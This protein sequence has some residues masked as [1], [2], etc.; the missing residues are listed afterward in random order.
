MV[1][2]ANITR[3]EYTILGT[4]LMEPKHAG[5]V[6]AVLSLGHFSNLGTR[7]LFEAVSALHFRGNP[8]DPVTV[9][10]EAG[11]D[12]EVAVREALQYCTAPSNLPYYC[13]MLKEQ[14]QLRRVQAEA[15]GLTTAETLQEARE[16]LDRL[17]GLMVSRKSVEILSATEAASD[18]YDQQKKEKPEYLHWGFDR[19]D[20][21]LYA[22]LGDFI[23]V[24]GYPSAGKTLLSLQFALTLAEKYRVGY[25][26]L[27]TSPQKLID[28]V[29]SHLSK[30]P[31]KKIKEQDL[32][33]ADYAALAEANVKL[34]TRKLDFID[35][36]GMT[37]RDIQA[38]A[39]N[40][41]Y[42]V[43]LVDYLQKVIDTNGGRRFEQVT[44]IS[45]N[46][47]TL[48]RVHGI[49]VIA[50]AQLS[51]PE[52]ENGKPKPPNLSDFRESGQIEQDADIAMLLWPSD[53]ND[54]HSGRVLKVG[55][56]RD[57]ERLKMDLDF[58]GAIQTMVPHVPTKGEQYRELQKQIRAAGR[59]ESQQ[60][61]F[62]ELVG[63]DSELP[64]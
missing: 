15:L 63:D 12:Y 50:L 56:N 39:L 51:R 13:E 18:F 7:G 20:A 2:T 49:A 29:R 34:S 48:A 36:G 1:D 8:V 58:D 5:E 28:R 16:V 19:L 46:L 53:H 30:V 26:S 55:K 44:N 45:Q 59:K 23:V 37:V 4:V 47:Q 32:N 61:T 43:I 41:R 24:G 31:L 40:K 57:G 27:E 62:T 33:E 38:V 22:E 64:F 42:Q 14:G 35:A 9:V 17:N 25:F 10:Q 21:D 3:I 6:V 11:A 54:N 52:K 60:T